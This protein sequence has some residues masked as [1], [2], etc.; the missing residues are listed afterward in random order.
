MSARLE[1]QVAVV[2]GAGGGI[3][4]AEAML[5]A[6]EGAKVVVNNRV[7][8]DSGDATPSAETVSSEI[9]AAGGE[10]VANLDDVSSADGAASLV[11]AALDTFGRLDIVL[12]NAGVA[13]VSA[14][15]DMSD[16][17][18]NDVLD[19]SLRGT[20]NVC[21]A[22][23]P[24]LRAGSVILNTS[25]ESGLGHAFLSAYAVAKEGVV[26][27]TRSLARELAVDGIRCN[28]IRPR[29]LGTGMGAKFGQ[30]V[31]PYVERLGRLGPY[32]AG[33]RGGVGGAGTADEAAPLAVWLCTP[34]ALQITGQVFAIE[35]D[36]VGIWAEPA[37]TRAAMR[38]G[39]WDLDALDAALPSSVLEGVELRGLSQLYAGFLAEHQVPG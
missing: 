12:N 15:A 24:H 6:R 36:S 39:G 34:A 35:G 29:A 37:I 1:G 30:E 21:R 14:V 11:Q 22:A 18:W 25:S 23:I 7:R 16:A 4:R 28:A 5:L 33:E 19:N 8:S 10:A 13:R 3:G 38:P 26:A 2:T 32:R 9:V 17:L 20:F 27:L 31:A